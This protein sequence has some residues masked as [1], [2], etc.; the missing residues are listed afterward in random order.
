MGDAA[1]ASGETLHFW[2]AFLANS[3]RNLIQSNS[4]VVVPVC[5]F[6]GAN[7]S[8]DG[9]DLQGGE[10][11]SLDVGFRLCNANARGPPPLLKDQAP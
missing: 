3:P 10:R 2:T 9:G 1:D 8:D 7:V 5:D 4:V 6:V 11:E